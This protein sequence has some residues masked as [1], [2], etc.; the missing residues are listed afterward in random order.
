MTKNDVKRDEAVQQIETDA[1]RPGVYVA[2][3]YDAGASEYAT[4]FPNRSRTFSL[5]FPCRVKPERFTSHT[6]PVTVGHAWRFADS[7]FIRPYGLSLKE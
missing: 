5:V 6:A 2:K 3:H 4:S 1:D 7:S